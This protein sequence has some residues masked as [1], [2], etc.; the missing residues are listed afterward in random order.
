MRTLVFVAFAAVSAIVAVATHYSYQPVDLEAFSDVGTPFYPDFEDPNEATALRVASYNDDTGKTD[1]F[2]V[3]FKDGNWRIPSHHD[4]PA[5]GEEQLAK[6]AASMVGVTRAAMVERTAAAH[7]RY[8][9]LDPL[10]QDVAGTEG[11][12]DRI[13]LS[14]GDE[15]LVDFIVG[16]EVE[17]E[18]DTYYVRR[19][20]EDRFYTANLG[21]FEISTK[22]SDWIKQDVLDVSKNKITELIIDR[23]QIDESQGAIVKGDYMVL[24]RESSTSD[25]KLKDLKEGEEQLKTT[26]IN[27]MLTALDD[28]AIV[29]VRPKPEGISADLRTA[30]SMSLNTLDMID[31]QE[32]G[33]F[34][35]PQQGRIFSN[36]GELLVGTDEGVL[37]ALRFGEEFSGTD[38]DIEVG[39]KKKAED[40]AGDSG[41]NKAED[42]ASESEDADKPANNAGEGEAKDDLLKSRYLFVTVQFDKDLIGPEPTAPTKPKPPA[43]NAE[44]KPADEKPADE[45]KTDEKKE[46][47]PAK[48]EAGADA[49]KP[50]EAAKPDPKAEYEKALKQYEEELE[51][52]EI[53][54]KDYEQ[55]VEEGQKR[56][57]DLNAR[58][59]DWFY[60]IS[61]DVFDRL[62]LDREN[63]VE[64]VEME[65]PATPETPATDSPAT[66]TLPEVKPQTDKPEMKKEEASK[67]EKPEEKPQPEKTEPEKKEAAEKPAEENKE[68]AEPKP[69]K[70]E[71][72]KPE[73]PAEETK[74]EKSAEEAKPE[75]P[76][77]TEEAAETKA[78]E[79]SAEEAPKSE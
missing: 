66:G 24:D 64:P 23:Y 32:R 56:V 8:G 16:N 65:E 63:L 77:K 55:K 37:Y 29:G 15:T 59:A 11:R 39:S 41:E 1:V 19:A 48:D 10:D 30:K 69:E 40:K 53:K 22:F 4:Y 28:L 78:E 26:D 42:A 38:V 75:Q 74:P 20:D 61:A 46:A 47:E 17:G 71:D 51:V 25:W 60:V 31:L 33:F 3:E 9:L 13:T 44:D 43:E 79:K 76:E 18:A 14:S 73:P 62:K 58:F 27:N 45:A 5:D 34:I 52:Y 70:K 49:D 7:K 36:E 72:A 54:K 12:G 50:E 57:A 67:E 6:T 2:E 35:V 68:K 21:S